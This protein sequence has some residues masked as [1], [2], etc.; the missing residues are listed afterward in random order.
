M[1][2]PKAEEVAERLKAALP[3]QIRAAGDPQAMAELQQQQQSA[4]QGPDPR[5]QAEQIQAQAQM[6]SAQAT[7]EKAQLDLQGKRLEL[8]GKAAEAARKIVALRP[9]P[10]AMT[11]DQGQ[12]MP[13]PTG[14]FVG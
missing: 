5:V 11:G 7:M 13:A 14:P 3:P 9:Q 8:H 4:Q 6:A 2:W 10:Q 12:T 1:D